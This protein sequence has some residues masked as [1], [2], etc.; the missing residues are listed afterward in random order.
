M[1]NEQC[2]HST[3]EVLISVPPYEVH[4]C[5]WGCG[6]LF[7]NEFYPDLPIPLVVAVHEARYAQPSIW[8]ENPSQTQMVIWQPPGAHCMQY[9][10]GWG[11]KSH[12]LDGEQ[13]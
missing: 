8:D 10:I 3:S 11:V 6:A 7:V 2:P 5:T 9:S 12:H 13:V 4:K 1:S